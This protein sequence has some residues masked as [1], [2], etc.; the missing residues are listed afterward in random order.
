ML[1][2]RYRKKNIPCDDGCQSTDSQ[3][4]EQGYTGQQEDIFDL[5][6]FPSP[7]LELQGKHGNLGNQEVAADEHTDKYGIV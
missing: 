7:V 2:C 1:G 4:G 6:P 5:V 3:E